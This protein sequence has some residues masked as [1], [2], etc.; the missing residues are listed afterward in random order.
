MIKNI[1]KLLKFYG[2]MLLRCDLEYDNLLRQ[3]INSG[4]DTY[5]TISYYHSKIKF[6]NGAVYTY[7]NE[8]FPYAWLSEYTIEKNGEVFKGWHTRPKRKTMYLLYKQILDY[9]SIKFSGKNNNERYD[10]YS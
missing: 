8:N 9:K 2:I 5:D 7:W 3:C 4:I 6:N 10:K 1:F